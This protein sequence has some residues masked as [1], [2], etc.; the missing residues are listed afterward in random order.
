MVA[1]S[2]FQGCVMESSAAKDTFGSAV[3]AGAGAYLVEQAAA[4]VDVFKVPTAHFAL[5]G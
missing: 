1:V 3:K 4:S 2:L 5:K